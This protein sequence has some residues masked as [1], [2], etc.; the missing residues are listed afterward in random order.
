MFP[1]WIWY[2]WLCF[3]RV[4]YLWSLQNREQRNIGNYFVTNNS[5]MIFTLCSFCDHWW[6]YGITDHVKCNS[7]FA[8][9]IEKGFLLRNIAF[10]N[11]E[12]WMR[13]N[14]TFVI[15][16]TT[17]SVC[18]HTHFVNNWWHKKITMSD[19]ILLIYVE[20]M[21]VF[22]ISCT[23]IE[24]H[25]IKDNLIQLIFVRTVP[26]LVLWQVDKKWR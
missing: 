7:F 17:C 21:Q 6:T 9:G 20:S 18:I 5:T 14:I 8:Y 23:A 19:G 15:F 16:H 11:C 3:S 12:L 26:S 4:A 2:C 13:R 25:Q 1:C 24:H 22:F 10:E